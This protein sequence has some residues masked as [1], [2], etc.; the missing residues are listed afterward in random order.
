MRETWVWSLGWE[1]PLEKEIATHSS[2]LAWRIPWTE[3]PGG[4][5][6]M[7][8]VGHDWATSLSLSPFIEH[9]YVRSCVCGLVTQLCPTLCNPIDC[10]P[11]G[12]SVYIGFSR[13]ECWSG[14]P[15][16]SPGD[17][18]NPGIE[19]RSSALQADSLPSEHQGNQE[20]YEAF[21]FFYIV[22]RKNNVDI[23]TGSKIKTAYASVT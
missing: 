10:S 14:L 19:P 8:R 18:P 9:L 7:Q 11:P 13:Q 21:F 2:I 6:I 3:E 17:L 5:Q 1:D 23:A 15:F 16:S 4:L 22:D 20:L 12:S